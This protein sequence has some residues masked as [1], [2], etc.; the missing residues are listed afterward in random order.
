MQFMRRPIING[1]G[2]SYVEARTRDMKRTDIIV[3]YGGEQFVIELKIWRGPKYHA[4]GEAQIAEYLDYY[5]LNTGYMLTFNF[6]QKKE[7]GVKRIRYGDRVLVEA[8]V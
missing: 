4:A 2:R 7:I 5:E 6:S 8:V 1:T 3:D